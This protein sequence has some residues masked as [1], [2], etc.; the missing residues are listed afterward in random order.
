MK[1]VIILLGLSIACGAFAA[2]PA[3]ESSLFDKIWGHTKLVD[4]PDATVL[5]SV[6]LS[7]RLQG[8]S[9]Y[10]SSD[11]HGSYDDSLWRRFRAGAKAKLFN[12]FTLHVEADLD[13]NDAGSEN[14]YSRLTDA[15]IS[16][17]PSKALKLKVGKQG[18]GFT[19]DGATSSKKLL[20]LERSIVAGNLW[21][22][23]EYFTGVSASGKANG[24]TYTI[25]GYSA[26][27]GDELG[28]T[29]SGWFSL[30]S[31]GRDVSETT[32]VRADYVHNEPDYAGNVGTRDLSDV[33][34]FITQSEFG[35]LGVSTDLSY[36]RGHSETDQSDLIA[37]QVMPH[38]DFTERWQGVVSY[39]MVHCTDG[40]GARMGRY[41][42]RNLSGDDYETVQELFM[43]VNCYI[44][45]DKLKWQTGVEYNLV[46]NNDAGDDYNGWGVTSG[47]RMSW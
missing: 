2:E 5:Q 17:S 4:N 18:V 10:F 20:T 45:G 43:G 42:S 22:G 26:D 30:V 7:G 6:A 13:L 31:L 1:K 29:D 28:T 9:A 19:L 47:F 21:F 14:I 12:D 41:A 36:A 3:T 8:D 39:A 15:Y 32:Y 23:T 38:Y 11:D 24:W 37:L 44:Y 35:K 40:P 34:S 33:I 46:H 16:W 25:G 27:E